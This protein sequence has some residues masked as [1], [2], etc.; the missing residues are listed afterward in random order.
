MENSKQLS[1]WSLCLPACRISESVQQLMQLALD[2][3]SEAVGS[4]TFWY[5]APG[6]SP[7]L[8]ERHPKHLSLSLSLCSFQLCAALL[9]REEHVPALL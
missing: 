4:S 7:S 9:H 2:T 3:L 1:A 6:D 8:S 5:V